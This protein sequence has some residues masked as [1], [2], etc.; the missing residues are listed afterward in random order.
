MQIPGVRFPLCP[1]S[2]IKEYRSVTS[3][4]RQLI[5]VDRKNL[6]KVKPVKSLV[7]GL[8]KTGGRNNQGRL[9]AFRKGGGHKRKYRQIT[10]KRNNLN[11][12]VEA[13][14]HD[15]NRSAFIARLKTD[16]GNWAYILAPEDLQIGQRIET[17]ERAPFEPGNALPL[18]KIPI[19]ST[20]HNIELEPGRGGQ[21]LRAAGAFGQLVEKITDKKLVRI[22]LISGEQRLINEEALATLGVVSNIDNKNQNLGK[23]GRNRWLGKRPVVRGVAMNPVDHPHGGGEGKTS[24]GRH[25]VTPWGRLTKGPKTRRTKRPNPFR[26]QDLN[27][28]R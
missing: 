2:N 5:L 19:G 15:P 20:I 8:T 26:L 18:K 14:E 13:I 27:K 12:V 11:G 22:K 24:G 6:S 9:T 10:F 4:Q 25:P 17:S 1:Y 28:R 23:A 7:K 3:S 21:F 16:Y